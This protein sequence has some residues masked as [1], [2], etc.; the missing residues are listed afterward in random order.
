MHSY[1]KDQGQE[2]LDGGSAPP[3]P[4]VDG[5][6]I[7]FVATLAVGKDNRIGKTLNR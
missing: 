3:E 5:P 4:D 2:F 1:Q 6:A 7:M